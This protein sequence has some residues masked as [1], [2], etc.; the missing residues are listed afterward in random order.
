MLY[1]TCQEIVNESVSNKDYKNYEYNIINTF[2]VS[3]SIKLDQFE[4]SDEKLLIETTF[5]KIYETYQ[6]RGIKCFHFCNK[7][8]L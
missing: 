8:R 5:K 4:N 2:S 6:K 1:D 3:P 7:K